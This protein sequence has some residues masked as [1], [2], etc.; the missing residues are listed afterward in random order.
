MGGSQILAVGRLRGKRRR[1]GNRRA[2]TRWNALKSP[3]FG[4]FE[5]A[6]SDVR[7]LGP[8]QRIPKETKSYRDDEEVDYCVVGV[9]S[10]GGVLLQR[11]AKAGFSVV[12]LEA[13]PFWD[14]ELDW[15]SDEK[16]SHKLYWN[17]LEI[18]G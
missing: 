12:G 1:V 2:R 10:A 14:T 17:G 7:N 18:T 6:R 11:L 13:G 3:L 16:G 5:R 9:G 15:V 4:E 8:L